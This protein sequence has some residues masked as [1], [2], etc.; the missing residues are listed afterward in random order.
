MELLTMS[1]KERQ[2]LDMMGR[3]DR[4]EVSRSQAARTLNMCERQVYRIYSRW[5]ADGDCG[6]VHHSR[7]GHSGRGYPL[8]TRNEVVRLYRSKYSDYSPTLFSE[9]L[10]EKYGHQIHR[11]T[12]RRWLM[13]F[14][15]WKREE[16]GRK[17]SK[18]RRMRP[19]RAAFGEMLQLDGSFHNWFEGRNPDLPEVTLLVL[20]DDATGRILLRF[21]R[22][23][24][25]H[26]VFEL[27]KKYYTRY[28]IPKS[29][30]TD[31]GSVYYT[32]GGTTQYERAMKDLGVEVIRAH[33]PQAKGRVERVNRTLQD[34]LVKE[35]REANISTLE[36]ANRFVDEVYTSKFN[37]QFAELIGGFANA[38]RS[39]KD[40]KLDRIFSIENER[41]VRS[42]NTV[43]IDTVRWQIEEPN[44]EDRYL[45]PLT[46]A[47]VETRVYLDG[48]VHIFDGE[49]ELR[50]TQVKEYC[51]AKKCW[52]Y[53]EYENEL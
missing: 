8:K 24:T 2:K 48:T 32:E 4:G 44:A 46:G 34:R 10:S 38:H 37:R 1:K 22:G 19:R 39:T 49:T 42:D 50:V 20:I 17:R 29:I 41:V 30:Y 47:S 21:S 3:I 36:D 5:K 13:D 53:P 25:T 40:V 45:A 16:S 43:A 35:L 9:I 52:E 31:Y 33:S 51:G 7:G 6:V 14:G 15:L 18:H 27:L 23:E 26:G 12:L 28:G 11:E